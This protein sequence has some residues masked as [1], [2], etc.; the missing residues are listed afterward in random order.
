M[1]TYLFVIIS[2]L[3]CFSCSKKEAT[4]WNSYISVPI[5]NSSVGIT[6]ILAN[7]NVSL[8]N[9]N[10]ITVK[11]SDTLYSLELDSVISIPDTSITDTFFVDVP[12]PFNVV[13]GAQFFYRYKYQ[14]NK[15]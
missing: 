15:F 8:D 4:R 11:F 3:F 5:V 2:L 6:D 13:P 10:S 9:D 1:K 12:V 7:N 14:R